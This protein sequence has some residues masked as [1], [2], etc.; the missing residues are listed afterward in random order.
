VG[1]DAMCVGA[2]PDD[3][4]IGMGATIAGMVRRGLK[5]AVVDLTNGEP[6]PYGTPETRAREADEAA[7][8]LGVERRTL[9]QPNR[10]LFDTAEARLELA[11]VIREFQP[12]LLFVPY[13]KDA[14]PDHVAAAQIALAARFYGKLT[15]TELRHDPFYA[16]RVYH[17]MAV[18]S[19]IVAEP[20]FIADV[21]VDH[22][23]KMD[24][25]GAYRSQFVDNERNAGVL[26]SVALW[27]SMW[28]SMGRVEFGEPFFA[29]EP[30][31]VGGPEDLR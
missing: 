20:S 9:G 28:G 27:G 29:H 31:V 11:E 4:E 7:R 8:V 2:H 21:S 15:K 17:Y 26:S 12:R 3:V 18:H 14:H 19:R 23:T 24:A 30:V 10:F 5:V 22:K 16:E 25:L 13:P 1:Y 6:T